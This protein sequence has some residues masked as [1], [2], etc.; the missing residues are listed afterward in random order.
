MV[1]LADLG[2]AGSALCELVL[3]SKSCFSFF[4]LPLSSLMWILA[5]RAFCAFLGFL[6]VKRLSFVGVGEKKVQHWNQENEEEG[7]K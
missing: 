1:G 4:P 6:S 5:F 7:E 2:W 3:M